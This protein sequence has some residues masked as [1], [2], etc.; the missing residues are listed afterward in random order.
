M[1]KDKYRHYFDIDPDYFP[2]VNADV[3][4][5]NPDLWKKFYPHDTFVKLLKHTVDVLTR[6]QKLNIWVEGAYGTGK[7]HAVLTLKRLLD[8]NEQ[9]TRDYFAQFNLDTDLCNK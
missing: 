9:D 3:I 8:A 5:K 6:K 2:A 1:D 7:S 4:K